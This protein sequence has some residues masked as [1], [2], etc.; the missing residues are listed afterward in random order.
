M[1]SFSAS[2]KGVG[3]QVTRQSTHILS[4]DSGLCFQTF[5]DLDQ[6]FQMQRFGPQAG[7]PA[8]E[9]NNSNEPHSITVGAV[10]DRATSLDAGLS[11]EEAPCS[12]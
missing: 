4:L 8:I 10:G 6:S 12:V 11:E 9:Q 5:V 2:G 3:Q 7:I 1:D